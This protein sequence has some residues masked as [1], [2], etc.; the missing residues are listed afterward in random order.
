MRHVIRRTL[1]RASF[2]NALQLVGQ[3]SARQPFG[4]PDPVLHGSSAIE[5]YTGGLWSAADLDL[6]TLEPRPLIAELFGLGFRWAERPRC[7]GRC[8]WHRE[9]HIG[10][11]IGSGGAPSD[12]A[13]LSNVLT[14]INDL[15]QR[16]QASLK[17]IGIED[18]IAAQ[19]SGCLMLRTPF[20]EGASLTRVLV[21]L[22]RE[23]VGGRCRAGY[24]QRRVTWDTDGAVVLEGELSGQTVECDPAPRFMGLTRMQAL[25]GSWHVRCGFSF[26]RPRLAAECL[27]HEK[28]TKTD[29]PRNEKWGRA[30]GNSALVQNVIP[31]DATWP[32]LSR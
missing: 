20:S 3:A 5:L 14:V 13:E 18:L 4:V 25:I 7:G 31:F 8:L 19:V 16:A 15:E 12:F 29:R 26:D 1:W 23:G 30:G 6:Y 22:A 24:L 27:R 2:I 32:V 10:I 9:L 11:N 21:A 17:V 28:P